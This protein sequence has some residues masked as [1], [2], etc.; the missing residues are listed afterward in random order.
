VQV[1]TNMI[2]YGMNPQVALD[3]PRFCIESGEAGGHVLVEDSIPADVV[4]ALRAR[5]VRSLS[6][7][8]CILRLYE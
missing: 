4:T 8:F 5:F 3:M 7:S 1:L 2:D 6:L